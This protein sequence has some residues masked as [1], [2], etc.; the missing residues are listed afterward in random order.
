M[1]TNVNS[2]GATIFMDHSYL[3]N[4]NLFDNCF[5]STVPA[6][7]QRGEDAA[8]HLMSS[9]ELEA[10]IAEDKPLPN[11]RMRFYRKGGKA[12]AP[13]DLRNVNKAA[14]N[15]L[16]DGAFNVNSTS[17]NAWRSLLSSLSGNEIKLWNPSARSADVLSNL[18]NPIPRFWSTTNKGSVNQPFEGMRDLTDAQV[19]DLAEQIVRQVKERGPF[20]HMGDFLN[21]RLAPS[22]NN[23]SQLYAMGALQA[24]IENTNINSSIRSAGTSTSLDSKLNGDPFGANVYGNPSTAKTGPGAGNW[25]TSLTSSNTSIPDNTTVG[26]PGYLMQQDLVQAF[27]PVMAAR[28]D[29]FVIRGY[30]EA[31]N[32]Q[33]VVQ[34]RAWCEAV[35]QRLPDYI[36]QSDPALNANNTYGNRLGDATPPYL[37]RTNAADPKALVNKTNETF[38][39]KFAMTSF[40]WLNE[41]EI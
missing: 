35:V 26:I 4:L 25:V 15:L 16:V 33:G 24:A 6:S 2:S 41:K 17:V 37:R 27:A 1:N 40:R 18:E 12:P 31:R 10:A 11:N 39:R 22:E 8:K 19:T 14:A 23:K 34:A 32:A 7:D 28:S 3:A 5:F 38:G 21:R 29:T 30:G 36:D 9:S 13:A 20:L